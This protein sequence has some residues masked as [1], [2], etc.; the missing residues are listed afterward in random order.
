MIYGTSDYNEIMCTVSLHDSSKISFLNNKDQYGS[1]SS[2]T[3]LKIDNY[4]NVHRDKTSP[5][6]HYNVSSAIQ[7]IDNNIVFVG[8]VKKENTAYDDYTNL[9]ISKMDENGTIFWSRQYDYGYKAAAS[10]IIELS[11]SSLLIVGTGKLTYQSSLDVI[12]VYTDNHGNPIWTRSYGGANDDWGNSVILCHDSTFLIVGSCP[13]GII[14]LNINNTGAIKWFKILNNNNWPYYNYGADIVR[15]SFN[16]YYITGSSGSGIFCLKLNYNNEIVWSKVYNSRD[17][18][19]HFGKSILCLNDSSI[20]IGGNFANR[21]NLYRTEQDIALININ[22]SG[23]TL[24]TKTIGGISDDYCN[25]ITFDLD[26]GILISGSTFGFSVAGNY[27]AYLIKFHPDSLGCNST[28]NSIYIDTLELTEVDTLIAKESLVSYNLD[29]NL[30][31][32]T[33]STY[34]ACTCHPP[35]AFFEYEAVDGSFTL[36][37]LASWATE[38]IWDIDSLFQT[39]DYITNWYGDEVYVCLQVQNECG[40]DKYCE[41]VN[42]G[43]RL[44]E[45]ILISPEA[46]PVPSSDFIHLTCDQN[47]KNSDIYVYNLSGRLIRIYK[48]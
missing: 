23:D 6:E 17:Y 41:I 44:N 4:G 48:I 29:L 14:L 5:M 16:N 11:D 24:W 3:M 12:A 30:L 39:T 22:D 21:S 28:M 13:S 42:G 47:I 18:N 26:S 40:T 46:Y 35:R 37:N 19:I 31:F 7:T 1:V 43:V 15:D 34:D 25:S 45:N 10:K 32:D 38:W 36:I 27:D 9:F 8:S 20:L 2:I 33:I